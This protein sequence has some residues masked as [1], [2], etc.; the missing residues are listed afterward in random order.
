VNWV[1]LAT[2]GGVTVTAAIVSNLLIP[3]AALQ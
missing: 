3:R 2:A 1:A